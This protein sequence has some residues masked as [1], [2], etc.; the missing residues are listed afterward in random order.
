MFRPL[1]VDLFPVGF[2]RVNSA[3]TN[4]MARSM[5]IAAIFFFASQA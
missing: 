3:N 5:G 2:G 4:S 1:L